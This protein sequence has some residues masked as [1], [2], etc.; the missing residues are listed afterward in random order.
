M[1]P[2]KC[3]KLNGWVLPSWWQLA[4]W[5]LPWK[6]PR[7][8]Y[9][10]YRCIRTKHSAVQPGEQKK[11]PHKA[12]IAA[13][14]AAKAE[15]KAAK[16]PARVLFQAATKIDAPLRPGGPKP[17]PAPYGRNQAKIAKKDS[18][19]LDVKVRILPLI[20]GFVIAVL[21]ALLLVKAYSAALSDSF[22]DAP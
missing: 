13:S 12:A 2:L 3:W 10:C 19:E 20:T 8:T 16:P 11:G 18:P 1:L 22:K 21:H 7:F 9:W 17:A 5:E 6:I 15:A 14:E 4:E